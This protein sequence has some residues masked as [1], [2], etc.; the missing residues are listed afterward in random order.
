MGIGRK[1]DIGFGILV[2]L[3]LSVV[4]LSYLGGAQATRTI[5]QTEQ[6]R[7]PMVLA[8]SQAQANLLSMLA[9]TRGYL[10]LGDQTY[11]DEYHQA[12]Q[13]FELNLA[14]LE[15]LVLESTSPDD[16][17]HLEQLKSLF[18]RWSSLPDSL[19]DLRDD[20]LKR[21]PA[22][23]MLTQD[24]QPFIVA[25]IRSVRSM[26]ELQMQREA[27]PENLVLLNE[28]GSYE[29]SFFAILAGLRGYVTTGRE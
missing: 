16:Q 24:A 8:S 23:R 3:T 26:S 2:I 25:I 27:T 14:M 6:L 9:S 10:A 11:R 4:A 1:L 20:Q 13:A 12:K 28:I 7:V 19:F 18:K 5:E 17:A 29:S 22:L 21:E 15:K